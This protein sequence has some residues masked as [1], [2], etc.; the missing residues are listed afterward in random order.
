MVSSARKPMFRTT[1][2]AR[3]P[4][5]A[6]NEAEQCCRPTTA[7]RPQIVDCRHFRAREVCPRC[8]GTGRS[9]Y[10]TRSSPAGR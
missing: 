3:L 9:I 7:S 10:G 4:G 5:A 1:L 2:R 8:R 6:A